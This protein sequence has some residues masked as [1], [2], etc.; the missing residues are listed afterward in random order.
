[1]ADAEDARESSVDA[2]VSEL[3]LDMPFGPAVSDGA[4]SDGGRVSRRQLIRRAGIGG[5]VIIVSSVLASPALAQT[6][7]TDPNPSRTGRTPLLDAELATKAFVE[8]QRD[9][10]VALAGD[11]MDGQLLFSGTEASARRVGAPAGVG[12]PLDFGLVTGGVDRLVISAAGEVSFPGPV[13]ASGTLDVTDSATFQGQVAVDP[14]GSVPPGQ[15]SL[16]VGGPAEFRSSLTVAGDL[17]ADGVAS[18]AGKVYVGHTPTSADDASDPEAGDL[19]TN[20]TYVDAG[21]ASIRGIGARGGRDPN[22]GE[23]DEVFFENDVQVRHSYT[24]GTRYDQV[25]GDLVRDLSGDPVILE[26]NALSAGPVSIAS[27]ADVTIPN[28]SVWTIV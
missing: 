18:F 2:E 9:T 8:Q 22:T 23:F 21:L 10:R 5:G 16:D 27:D 14:T 3:G 11:T 6:A 12:A 15:P 24:I 26:K 19:A 4:V 28:G 25:T 20:K 7:P 1:M 13:S 17:N